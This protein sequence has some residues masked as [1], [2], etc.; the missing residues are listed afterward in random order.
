MKF[1]TEIGSTVSKFLAHR[2]PLC[3]FQFRPKYSV[4]LYDTH[5][6]VISA[7]LWH[8]HCRQF[9]TNYTIF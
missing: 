4:Y 5:N 9:P 3:V 1:V 2:A 8:R 7:R 6:D